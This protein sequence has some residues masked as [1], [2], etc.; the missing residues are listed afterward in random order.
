[1]GTS[2][3]GGSPAGTEG[4]GQDP[5]Q[6]GSST[7]GQPTGA[8]APGAG[9][10]A[11]AGQGTGTGSGSLDRSKLSE[12]LRHLS[13]EQLNSVVDTL[14]AAVSRKGAGEPAAPAEPAPPP[15]PTNE[16][17]K[18]LFDPASEKF[19]PAAAISDIVQRNYGGVIR[20]ISRNATR[21]VFGRFREEFSDFK[22]FERDIEQALQASGVVNPTDAQIQGVYFAAKGQRAAL[23]ERQDRAAALRA[24]APSPAANREDV[25]REEPLEDE[26]KLV[27]RR[28]FPNAQDPEKAYREYARKLDQQD[29]T[30]KVPMGG[31]NRR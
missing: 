24:P 12:P 29:T 21:A 10:G 13:E 6:G 18:D 23:K 3:N 28:M 15:P 8:G 1:M 17:Y 2:A 20:D 30:M 7:P 16:D 27:A 11:G 26:E 4:A 22:E 31:G 14:F 19:N 5:T 25:P 9:E